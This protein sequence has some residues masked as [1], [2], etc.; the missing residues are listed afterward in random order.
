[1]QP[2]LKTAAVLVNHAYHKLLESDPNLKEVN[3]KSTCVLTEG[4]YD[5]LSCKPRNWGRIVEQS[6]KKKYK[7]IEI[8]PVDCPKLSHPMVFTWNDAA[9]RTTWYA[10]RGTVTYHNSVSIDN[11]IQV[12]KNVLK[13]PEIL[14]DMEMLVFGLRKPSLVNSVVN[15]ILEDIGRSNPKPKH[16]YLTG[17]SLGGSVALRSKHVIGK[18]FPNIRT[19]VIAFAPFV[20]N[21]DK[22]VDPSVQIFYH[23]KDFVTN[24]LFLSMGL[25]NHKPQLHLLASRLQD[26]KEWH[27]M[28]C[29]FKGIEDA[30]EDVATRWPLQNTTTGGAGENTNIRSMIRAELAKYKQ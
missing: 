16:V 6:K 13:E 12:L 27:S 26:H 4:C 11:P 29:I 23:K 17:H 24:N 3:P 21:I 7:G 18:K 22:Y 19:S 20:K 1:M 15:C 25:K 2:E 30:S 9:K 8:R 5:Y 28:A 14:A 10:M